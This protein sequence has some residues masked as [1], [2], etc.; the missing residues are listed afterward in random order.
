MPPKLTGEITIEQA[1]AEL[2]QHPLRAAWL[3]FVVGQGK[4]RGEIRVVAKCR[5]GYPN[6]GQPRPGSTGLKGEAKAR[7]LHVE[8]G[9]IPLTCL[10]TGRLLTPFISHIIGYNLK[11]VSHHAPTD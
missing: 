5:Q 10:D 7:P 8:R 4:G 11:N 9:T 1:L 6:P 2:Q 3:C